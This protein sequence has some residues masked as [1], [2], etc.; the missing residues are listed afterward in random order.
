MLESL[1]VVASEPIVEAVIESP[2]DVLTMP[3]IFVK[4]LPEMLAPNLVS[5]SL[6]PRPVEPR[7][8]V[9]STIPNM[10]KILINLTEFRLQR[11][12]S[13]TRVRSCLCHY[14]RCDSPETYFFDGSEA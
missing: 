9:F 13:P 14:D 2:T 11:N 3:R 4:P 8:G 5:T 6:Y 7:L 12:L 1:F 10:D